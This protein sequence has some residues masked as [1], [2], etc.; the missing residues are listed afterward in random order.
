MILQTIGS[1]LAGAIGAALGWVA[2]EFVAR[3]IRR[4][5]DL[6]GEIIRRM[7]QY[8][9]VRARY[10]EERDEPNRV[11]E[12]TLSEA[13]IAKL[14]EA[15]HAIRDLATQMRAFA[16]NETFAK[17]ILLLLRYDLHKASEGLFGVSNTL[18]TYGGS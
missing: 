3:P 12:L 10:K 13:E 4:F 14:D 15:R 9:N 18:D 8:A 7:A 17:W 2:L 1:L 5:Y 11:T 6:R 16:L